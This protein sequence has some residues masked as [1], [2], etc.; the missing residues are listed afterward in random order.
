MTRKCTIAT[1]LPR[2]ISG[3]SRHADHKALQAFCR[4]LRPFI[5][6]SM[7]QPACAAGYLSYHYQYS[8]LT[9][10]PNSSQRFYR[11]AVGRLRWLRHFGDAL[12][13]VLKARTARTMMRRDAARIFM[14]MEVILN[15]LLYQ[16]TES[17]AE[18]PYTIQ[19]SRVRQSSGHTA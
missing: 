10:R 4:G 18:C 14:I 15:M 17:C 2:S 1:T 12:F 9:V 11:V 8:R 7:S 3:I 13:L 5:R 19:Y 6:Q 16:L